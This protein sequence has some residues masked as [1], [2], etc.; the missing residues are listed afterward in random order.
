M[1]AFDAVLQLVRC[2][3][4]ELEHWIAERWVLPERQGE[5]WLFQEVDVARL[6][7]IVE[8][9]QDLA[10]DEEAMPLVLHLL[11]QIYALR[12]RMKQLSAALD[13]LPPETRKLI[14]EQLGE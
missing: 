13:T 4:A 1:I 8:L 6:H 3:P 7:L 12:R 11:D 14:Q 9:R 5:A 2:Q 10:I